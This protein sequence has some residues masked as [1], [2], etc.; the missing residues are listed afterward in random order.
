VRCLAYR[1]A[2]PLPSGLPP[3][4]PMQSY[5]SFCT[6]RKSSGTSHHRLPFDAV[7]CIATGD[8]D[9]HGTLGVSRGVDV[10]FQQMWLHV[11]LTAHRVSASER[12]RLLRA[13]EHSCIVLQ[14]LR[15]RVSVRLE[16]PDLAN[17][18]S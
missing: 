17:D 5:S 3:S 12:R 13:V 18:P 6:A 7:R 9:V 10:G 15:N 1:A 14:T 16:S 2:D 4:G 8:V 11:E